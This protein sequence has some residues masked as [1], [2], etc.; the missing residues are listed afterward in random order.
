MPADVD[1]CVQ[2]STNPCRDMLHV[3]RNTHGHYTCELC[4]TGY[5]AS[6][7]QTHCIGMYMYILVI[8]HV[9]MIKHVIEG[10]LLLVQCVR[11]VLVD[12]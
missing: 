6:S 3:C 4:P 2:N 5:K 11:V 12:R 7:D 8:K 1:E 9:T 10:E